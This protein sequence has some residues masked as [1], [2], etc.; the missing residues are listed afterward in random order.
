MVR[1]TVRPTVVAMLIGNQAVE[2]Y[3]SGYKST[4]SGACGLFQRVTVQTT[5]PA[6][7]YISPGSGG[8]TIGDPT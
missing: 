7:D 5:D 2:N 1:K 6:E 8:T 3:C 4:K